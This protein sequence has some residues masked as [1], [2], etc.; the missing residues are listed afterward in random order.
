MK[1]FGLSSTTAVA[2]LYLSSTLAS[3]ETSESYQV[4]SKIIHEVGLP[5]IIV[6]RLIDITTTLQVLGHT[7][8]DVCGEEPTFSANTTARYHFLVR[9]FNGKQKRIYDCEIPKGKDQQ[10]T[11]EID[12]NV[13]HPKDCKNLLKVT[14][15]SNYEETPIYTI[16]PGDTGDTGDDGG[17]V[18]ADVKVDLDANAKIHIVDSGIDNPYS[19]R[20]IHKRWN[21]N[22]N[23]DL[24]PVKL[25]KEFNIVDVTTDDSYC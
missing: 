6:P 3:A 11:C 23:F 12:L 5:S 10:K 9:W 17:H 18:K 24:R 15:S 14:I 8:G 13:R 1:L 20:C 16:N 2:L 7:S 21:V 25:N 19:Q 22:K 4:K